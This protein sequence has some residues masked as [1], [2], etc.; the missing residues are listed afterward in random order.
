ML[1]PLKII[2]LLNY[3][4]NSLKFTKKKGTLFPQ[5][6]IFPSTNNLKFLKY[7]KYW[8][9]S[10]VKVIKILPPS[11]KLPYSIIIKIN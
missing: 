1:P 11:K 5:N 9:N 3:H 10:G 4:K 2:T 6:P 8:E 7:V